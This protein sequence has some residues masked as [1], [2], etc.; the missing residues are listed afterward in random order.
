MVNNSFK[1]EILFDLM[2]N[3]TDAASEEKLIQKNLP[4]FLRK[5]NCFMAFIAKKEGDKQFVDKQ[6]LPG[7][8]KKNRDFI[9][10]ASW[11]E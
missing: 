2:N 10:W 1:A 3:L 8:F 6:I 9:R 11:L 4:V 7:I 5:L